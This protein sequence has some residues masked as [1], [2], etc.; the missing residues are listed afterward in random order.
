VLSEEATNTDFYSLWF[1]PIEASTLTITPPMQ[2]IQ[3]QRLLT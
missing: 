1:D 2:Y 3:F